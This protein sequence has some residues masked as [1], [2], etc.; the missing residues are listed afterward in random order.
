MSC[1]FPNPSLP[2]F[3]YLK[4]TFMVSLGQDNLLLSSVDTHGRNWKMIAELHFRDRSTLSLK[5]RHALLLRRQSRESQSKEN[6][7]QSP[8]TDSGIG[9]ASRQ[10]TLTTPSDSP[11]SSHGD[12]GD[13][14]ADELGNIP[15]NQNDFQ[16]PLPHSNRTD[17]QIGR[18]NEIAVASPNGLEGD[19]FIPFGQS[20]NTSIDMSAYDNDALMSEMSRLIPDPSFLPGQ[21]QQSHQQQHLY[22]DM[23]A[24]NHP[25]AAI[26][27]SLPLT[28][29]SSMVPTPKAPSDDLESWEDF[30]CLG[31][32]CPRKGLE[33]FKTAVLEAATKG[34]GCQGDGDDE[35]VQIMLKIRK[36][37]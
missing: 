12:P 13:V 1:P 35:K 20:S 32:N 21:P 22:S 8:Y 31:I 19:G 7:P 4:L 28:A 36:K 18:T 17:A 26:D 5:N 11:P 16:Y 10:I 30:L 6:I 23:S 3:F 2:P 37:N 15:N 24:F 33:A 14:V 34:P 29:R 25:Q 9:S 27:F